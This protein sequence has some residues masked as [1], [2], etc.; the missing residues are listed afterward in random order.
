MWRAGFIKSLSA[1][2]DGELAEGTRASFETHLT[3]CALCARYA[4]AFEP[5]LR[6]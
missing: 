2:H 4:A 3:G 6:L 1:W 5:Q